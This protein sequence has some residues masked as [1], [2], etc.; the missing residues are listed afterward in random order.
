MSFLHLFFSSPIT[1][2]NFIIIFDPKVIL[3]P[4]FPR[5]TSL[6]HIITH[7]SFDVILSPSLAFVSSIFCCRFLRK[8]DSL[9]SLVVLDHLTYQ[10]FDGNRR[11]RHD[12]GRSESPQNPSRQITPTSSKESTAVLQSCSLSPPSFLVI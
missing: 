1:A 5:C 4:H 8:M 6:Y 2:I 9:K 11:S 10:R 7:L 3:S 12:D